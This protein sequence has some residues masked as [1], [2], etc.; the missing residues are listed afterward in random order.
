MFVKKRDDREMDFTTVFTTVA[1]AARGF[2]SRWTLSALRSVDPGL[3]DR[4]AQQRAL[5]EEALEGGS[6]SEVEKH[7]A[8]LVR[9]YIAITKRMEDEGAADDAYVL[10]TD[11]DTGTVVAIG[12]QV[13]SAEHVM[14]KHKAVFMT[15]DEAARLLARSKD[16]VELKKV[17]PGAEVM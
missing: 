14:A 13:A 5:W 7:T 11:Y 9:G 6:R 10:G 8:A 3:Y 12:R 16:I 17:F 1:D 15:P 4:F 2:E